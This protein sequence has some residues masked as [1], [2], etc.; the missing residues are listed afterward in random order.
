MS[1]PNKII[2]GLILSTSLGLNLFL[3]QQ[4]QQSKNTFKVIGIIDGDSF[5]IAPDHTVRLADIDAPDLKL[6]GGQEAK[7]RLAELILGKRIRI[8][9]SSIDKFKRTMG[10]IYV[11]NKFVNKIMTEEGLVRYRPTKTSKGDIIKEAKDQ[12][13]KQ[14]IG[15]W[16]SKCRQKTNPVNPKCNIKGNIAKNSQ[17]KTYHLP[18]C[19]EYDRTTVE[20]D[21]GEQ[22]FCTEKEARLAGYTRSQHCH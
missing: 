15:I 10:L 19:Q 21:T 14:Q 6:C 12:A 11:D 7:Q 18:N 8:K 13:E 4:L 9:E 16:S 22:W 17:T 5:I 20:L 1:K 3:G 2:L